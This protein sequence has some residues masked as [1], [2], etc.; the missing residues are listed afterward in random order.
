[1]IEHIITKQ[2]EHSEVYE[3]W[4]LDKKE[5]FPTIKRVQDNLTYKEAQGWVK[6]YETIRKTIKGAFEGVKPKE[7]NEEITRILSNSKI[8]GHV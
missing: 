8:I 6:Y 3:V 2:E 5:G 7:S 4:R 1:M